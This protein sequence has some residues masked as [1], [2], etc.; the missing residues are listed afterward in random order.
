MKKIFL[1]TLSRDATYI[2]GENE[3]FALCGVLR[4]GWKDQR[5]IRIICAGENAEA[6][7]ILA[8]HG[9]RADAF[10]IEIITEQRAH[11]SHVRVE[12]RSVLADS[13]SVVCNGVMS[14]QKKV[15]GAQA[16]FTHHALLLSSS[17]RAK[18]VPSLEIYSEDVIAH[19][20]V[21]VGKPDDEQI[22]YLQSRGLT[23]AAAIRLLADGFL[24]RDAHHIRD[25][26][27]RTNFLQ[28]AA[29]VASPA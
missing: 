9:D 16:S 17:A 3:S 21:S 20:A 4:S 15:R 6:T 12:M 18:I 22:M 23:S 2:I 8:I 29:Y 26:T 27:L 13:A 11:H 25:T 28:H 5:I 1:T 19:H 7:V 24:A 14:I 10:P